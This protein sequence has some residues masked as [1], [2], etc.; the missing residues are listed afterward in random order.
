VAAADPAGTDRGVA[1]S[2]RLQGQEDLAPTG[3]KAKA[4]ANLAA[5]DVLAVLRDEGRPA[6]AGEQAV[7]ARWSGWG[8]TPGLFDDR[9]D[10]WAALRGEVRARLDEAAW[11]AARRT[12][13]NAH[14]TPAEVV[15]AM[16]T[17]VR[18]LGFEGGRVLEPGCGAGSFIGLAP[19]GLAAPVRMVGVEL[20][21]TTVAVAQALYPDAEIRAEGFER[22]R[23]PAGCFDATI[24]NVPF[25]KVSLYDPVHNPSRLSLHNH[26]IVKSLALTRP[27][28]LVGVVTSRYTLDARNPVARREMAAL[29]DLV[30]AVRL[31]GGTMR[32]AAGTDAITDIVI[33]RRRAEGAPRAG[34][35]WDRVTT[36]AAVGGDVEVNEYFARH[37][38]RVLGQPRAGGGQY[39]R[40]DPQV[41]PH[42]RPLG[43]DLTAALA[44]VVEEA[45]RAGLRATPRVTPA[46]DLAGT[47]EADAARSTVTGLEAKEGSI[48]TGPGGTFA[49]ITNGVPERFE[50]KPRSDRAELAALLGLRDAVGDLLALEAATVDDATTAPA[51][52]VLNARYD[53]YVAGYGPLNRFKLVR[54]G[55]PD[56]E[57]GEDVMRQA[58]P[59]MG[60]FRRDPDYRSVMALEDFDPD[61]QLATKAAIFSVRVVAPRRPRL[62]AENAQDAL[63]ICLDEHGRVDL[64]VIAGLLGTDAADARSRLGDLVWDDPA[65]GNLETAQ[66]YLS[67]NVRAK[68]ADAEVAAAVDGRWAANVEALRAV[69]PVDVG[70]EEIDARL[71][72]PWVPPG[73]VAAFAAEVLDCPGALVEFASVTSTWAVQVRSYQRHTVTTA[74]E[75]GTP[76]AD[77][78]R[79]LEDALNQTATSVTDPL[80]D[81][82]RV[83][84]LP[85][86]L[87]AREKQEALDHRFAAWLWEDP[88]RSARLV[89]EYNARFNS[90]VLPTYDGSHLTLPGLAASFT[91]HPHQRDAVWRMICEPTV[92][93]AHDVGAGK[94]ATMAMGVHELRRLGLVRKPAIVVPNHMLDQF[95][96]EFHQ[97]YPQA[98]VLVADRDDR[99]AEG[100]RAFAARC[101]TGDWD[102]VIMTGSAF[103]QIPVS[104]ETQARFQARR[105]EEYRLAI[106]ESTEGLTVKRLEAAVARAEQNQARLLAAPKKDDGVPFDQLGV[107]YVAIDEAHYYKNRAFPSRIQGVGGA[108][109]QR[110]MDLDMK[111]SILRERHGTRVATFATAT[112][113]ANSVAEMYTMQAYLQPELLAAA[114]VSGFDAWAAQFGRTTTALELAPDGGS[115]RM[116]TRFARFR[117]VPELLTMFGAAAE[118]RS[119][120]EL[121]L[122]VPLVAGGQARNVVVSASDELGVYVASLVERAERVRARAVPVEVDNMLKISGDGRRAALDL[123][124]VGV[125]PDP[126]G[127]KIAVAADRIAELYVQG[128]EEVYLDGAGRPSPILGSLQVVFCDLGTPKDDG[129]WSVYGELRSQLGARGVPEGMVRFIHDV[130]DDQGKADLF[131]ACREGRVGVLVGSTDK[132]GVGTNVQRRLAAVH[133]LDAPWWPANIAQRDGRALRQGNQNAEVEINRYVTEGSF[134]VFMW[135]TLER[136]QAFIHQV[137]SGEYAGRDID[138]IGDVAL[139]YAEV[140]ALAT[141]NPLIME[142]AGVDSDVA[143]LQRL[144]QA[145]LRDQ[146]ALERRV[147]SAETGAVRAERRAQLAAAAVAARIDTKGAAFTMTVGD[148]VHTSRAAAGDQLKVTLA[149]MGRKGQAAA[150]LSERGATTTGTAVGHLAGFA[151]AVDGHHDRLDSRFVLRLEGTPVEVTVTGSEAATMTGEGLVARLEGRVRGLEAVHLSAVDDAARFRA[152]AAAARRRLGLPFDQEQTLSGLIRRQAEL[153]ERLAGGDVADR[154]TAPIRSSGPAPVTGTV[155]AELGPTGAADPPDRAMQT[156]AEGGDMPIS[157]DPRQPK[158]AVVP[159]AADAGERSG[160]RNA[161]GPVDGHD[162]AVWSS[163]LVP[164][165]FRHVDPSLYRFES[166]A[167]PA[168]ALEGWMAAERWADRDPEAAL[169]L[170]RAEERL[171]VVAP[172]PMAEYDQLRHEGLN[173][174]EAMRSVAPLVSAATG[175]RPEQHPSSAPDVL[176]GDPSG[177]GVAAAAEG[178]SGGEVAAAAEG[179]SRRPFGPWV[180]LNSADDSTA[181]LPEPP[182][183][184]RVPT[185]GRHPWLS[186]NSAPGSGPSVPESGDEPAQG[187]DRGRRI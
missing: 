158:G 29:G 187:P 115:Y 126:A 76:R 147:T 181:G 100:R 79:L 26:F 118:V 168:A 4:R 82:R 141:G 74:S 38:E 54:T 83:V 111:L 1:P 94:T 72:A 155:R 89:E 16:W 61:T 151:A 50:V 143:R 149:T 139:S 7:L 174:A 180:S 165:P 43:P 60:Q 41:T 66:R 6:T 114:G 56:P 5:L 35:P 170:G 169:A 120:A 119:A 171:R 116:T 58:R 167:E 69:T 177:R 148:T 64:D 10:G 68:L 13:L 28:G 131:A 124:L 19:A 105:V 146:T 176:P 113:V 88:A 73:D 36:V 24:G 127:G 128:R 25:A 44:G 51:R 175:G 21:P 17:A 71:G 2:F 183:P 173:P 136:K 93:L 117:N 133:H 102:A 30:G 125:A 130:R 104:R 23:F 98:K 27:G 48:V 179:T 129:G 14:Y 77:G 81:G 166:S 15:E 134:D 65:S 108:G 163:F 103:K 109:S 63:A 157:D 45:G 123:R 156:T 11:A 97:L 18:D 99:T 22:T 53:A 186:L 91:P 32:S 162:R 46:P 172:G 152:E 67:G 107:D 9:D 161:P 154:Q 34:E 8:A 101:A 3:A 90:T 164:E 112:P 132:M 20:D 12:T 184:A 185:A 110:A 57:T 92:L 37:P 31:P 52:A 178:R 122:K 137:M 59:T 144:R 86:T 142:K 106:G 49:R 159:E 84:N 153:H 80:P 70:P 39:R 96:R 85:E 87:A 78:V 40:S 95:A 145:H 42:D 138:D 47:L 33:L 150:R 160:D 140:K 75:W 62:G 135:Q 121:N 55:W 182:G